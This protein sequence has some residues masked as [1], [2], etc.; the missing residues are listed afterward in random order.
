VTATAPPVI[1]STSRQFKYE[2]PIPDDDVEDDYN[3]DE[4]FVEEEAQSYGME[5]SAS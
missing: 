4:N 5:K 1:L 3:D 2:P